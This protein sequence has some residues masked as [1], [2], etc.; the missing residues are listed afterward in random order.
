MNIIWFNADKK[1][2]N[3]IATIYENNITLNK[4]T[5]NLIENVYSVML[6]LDYDKKI[7]IIKPL[8]KDLATRGDIPTKSQYVITIR[9]SYGRI[10]NTDIIREI[11]KI[12]D[13]KS[14]KETPKKFH[15]KWEDSIS[16][17]SINLNEEVY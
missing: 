11:K 5:C 10:S 7:L 3:C 12:I 17:L 2:K 13:I 16:A 6:G 14:L 15:V 1:S 4:Y 8:S 9:N